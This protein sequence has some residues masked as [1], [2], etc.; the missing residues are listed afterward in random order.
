MDDT[1]LG[2]VFVVYFFCTVDW[3]AGRATYLLETLAGET[4]G[5]PTH[6]CLE[7]LVIKKGVDSSSSRTY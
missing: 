6:V 2:S 1:S 7:K 5:W 3:V 4:S